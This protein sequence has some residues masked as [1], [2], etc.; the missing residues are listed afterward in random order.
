MVEY[1]A[2]L[3][4]LDQRGVWSL[5]NVANDMI[6]HPTWFDVSIHSKWHNHHFR[7]DDEHSTPKE[8]KAFVDFIESSIVGKQLEHLASDDTS[9]N[10]DVTNNLCAEL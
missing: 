3:K 7:I 8:H 5:G 2:F 1:T 9:S 4:G 6:D 10:T